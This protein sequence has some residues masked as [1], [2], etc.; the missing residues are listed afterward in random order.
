[1][2]TAA[3]ESLLQTPLS[4]KDAELTTFVKAEKLDL[5]SKPDP[6]PRLIQPRSPRYNAWVGRY[7]KSAEHRIYSAIDQIWGLETVM[8][9]YNA[10]DTARI[11]RKHWDQ[12]GDTVAIG[13]DASRFDQHVSV[14]ALEWEHSVYNALYRCKSLA[15]VLTWQ[16]ANR[17]KARTME[18]NVTYEVNGRRM[19]GDMNTSLGNKLLMCA[20][21]WEYCR[22]AGV[23]ASL[24]NNGDDCVVFMRR[25]YAAKFV[26][27]LDKWF[28]EMGFT[29]KVEPT[30]EVFEQIEFCQQR[31]VYD[32]SVWVMTRS[33][34]K[35]LAKDL[36]MIGVNPV[37][38]RQDYSGWAKG[39]GVAGL[40]AYGGMPVV[41]EVYKWMSSLQGKAREIN[42]YSGIG[43]AANG[44]V[45]TYKEPTAEC[46]ASYYLA[47]GLTPLRQ[48]IMEKQ[49]RAAVMDLDRLYSIDL[50]SDLSIT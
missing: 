43:A 15:E 16:V 18:G 8:S 30:V 10:T 42:T 25:R 21:V 29:M 20:M 46:R 6:A 50:V 22:H 26:A 34:I 40:A 45:R 48:V 24:A 19:S 23:K 37:A 39:V 38:V 14:Q 41:Q 11:L 17:G 28:R 35:G 47:W 33:P 12:W 49:I 1:L 3:A 44:S 32:G 2:Y 36:M 13:L 5:E 27:G 4:K 7:L 31:P 9:G